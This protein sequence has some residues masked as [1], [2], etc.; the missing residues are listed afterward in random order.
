[1]EVKDH[2]GNVIVVLY[3]TGDSA[4]IQSDGTNWHVVGGYLT[5]HR[6]VLRRA[7]AKELSSATVTLIDGM[8]TAGDTAGIADGNQI[9][10]RRNGEYLILVSGS[11]PTFNTSNI[12]QLYAF[13]NSNTYGTV[14]ATGASVQT[15]VG[16]AGRSEEHTS[17]LQS[18][19]NL[20]CRLLLEKKK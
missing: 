12:W 5:P 15:T 2:L 6:C 17:E 20:V 1:V 9:K 4:L 14:S 18:R 16:M 3:V 19:E 8:T 10:I 11:G 7:T 13:V